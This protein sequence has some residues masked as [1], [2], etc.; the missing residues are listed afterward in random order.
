[1]VADV[2]QDWVAAQAEGRWSLP[3]VQG[4]HAMHVVL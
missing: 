3:R 4:N 2:L 1:M